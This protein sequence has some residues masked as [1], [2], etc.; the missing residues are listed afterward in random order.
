MIRPK[1][2]VNSMRYTIL[3]P[4]FLPRLGI[5]CVLAMMYL[6][7]FASMAVGFYSAAGTAVEVSSNEQEQVKT[8]GAAESG[9]EFIRFQLAQVSIPP[10]TT[11]TTMMN[12]V[13]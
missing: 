1:M 9:L 3:T 10:N 8:L 6:V 7:L 12:A 13:Y 2:D 11:S 5:T 4:Q